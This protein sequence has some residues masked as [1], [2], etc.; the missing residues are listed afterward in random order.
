MSLSY[1]TIT[2]LRLDPLMGNVICGQFF[3]YCGNLCVRISKAGDGEWYAF[4]FAK[5][6]K[7][8]IPHSSR[9]M[10]VDC[11]LRYKHI[12]TDQPDQ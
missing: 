7:V 5:H 6:E 11:E 3:T 8:C 10:L 2:D 1:V 4:D 12:Y 9:V